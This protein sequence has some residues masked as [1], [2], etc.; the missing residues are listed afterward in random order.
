MSSEVF[1]KVRGE[2]ETVARAGPGE[3][4]DAEERGLVLAAQQG[5]RDAF[6]V[7]MRRHY[8]KIYGVVYR[9]CGGSDAEDITQEVFVK[10]FTALADFRYQ[11]AAG[12]RTWLYRIAV[13]AAINELRRRKRR[14][15]WEGPSLDEAVELD[16]GAVEREAPD[17][18]DTPDEALERQET[19]AA[20]WQALNALKPRHRQVLVLVDIEGIDYAEAAGIFA[21]P[22]GTLKSRVARARRAFAVQFRKLTGAT[23]VGAQDGECG[24]NHEL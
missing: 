12:L 22:V 9:M 24:V 13:N 19:R 5:D 1:I 21:C 14:S 4:V 10:A 15:G 18:A 2:T 3:D 8:R 6:T 20:V 16:S 7:L 11:R 23:V 17:D